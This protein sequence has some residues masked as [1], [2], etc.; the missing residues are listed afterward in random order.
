M[1]S[2][3]L[4]LVHPQVSHLPLRVGRDKDKDKDLSRERSIDGCPP[5]RESGL[6]DR[7][8][9]T[10]LGFQTVL[11]GVKATNG[12]KSYTDSGEEPGTPMSTGINLEKITS[13]AESW[14]TPCRKPGTDAGN[15]ASLSSLG[16]LGTPRSSRGVASSSMLSPLKLVGARSPC[17]VRLT[18][19]AHVASQVVSPAAAPA[20]ADVWDSCDFKYNR[21]C[22]W[23]RQSLNAMCTPKAQRKLN[24]ASPCVSFSPTKI[25]ECFYPAAGQ[26]Q[27][28]L[29]WTWK[30][31]TESPESPPPPRKRT[32]KCVIP[33]RSYFGGEDPPCVDSVVSAAL[34]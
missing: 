31:S 9:A 3:M 23:E 1:A 5:N 19:S 16:S 15:V 24:F 29:P 32:R 10:T 27:P 4:L 14:T 28:N 22:N 26:V 17:S 25:A 20:S 34:C 21:E 18:G 13:G 33:K 30:D 12:L 2:D 8:C 11:Q 7:S 6:S